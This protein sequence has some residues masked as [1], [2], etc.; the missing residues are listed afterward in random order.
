[1]TLKHSM[2]ALAMFMVIASGCGDHQKQAA[3]PTDRERFE[4]GTV[5]YL[6]MSEELNTL[7]ADIVDVESAEKAVP[8]L[9]EFGKR[10]KELEQRMKPQGKPSAETKK[11]LE[12]KYRD[13]L[14]NAQE[15]M[16]KQ[17]QRIREKQE[18]WSIVEAAIAPS[19][20]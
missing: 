15:N 14:K 16:F 20:R 12:E 7:L 3:E 2:I 18:V 11:Y 6:A 13:R 17:V 5:E 10:G 8:K 4:K 1:M 9:K 19:G